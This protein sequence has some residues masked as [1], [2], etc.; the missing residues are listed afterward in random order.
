M[1][2]GFDKN[3]NLPSGIYWV[4]WDEVVARFGNSTRR[5]ML[6]KGLREA[7]T[8]LARASC[9]ALYVDG[10][11]V[12]AKEIPGDF[13]AC[14][15]LTGVADTEL[16]PVFL[17]FSNRRRAQKVRFSGELFPA[18]WPSGV[19]SRTFL[20]FFQID[21]DGNPKGIIALDLTRWRT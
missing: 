7:A 10:S 5:A 12:T 19:S 17:D 3:G 8:L 9:R 18:E 20:Q 1:I 16:D 21:R 4:V 11:F 13:D 14:W 15:D 6:I 2:P